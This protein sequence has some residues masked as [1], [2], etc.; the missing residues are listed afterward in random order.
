MNK[1]YEQQ[2]LNTWFAVFTSYD[3]ISVVFGSFLLGR[4][5]H[6]D[7]VALTKVRFQSIGKAADDIYLLSFFCYIYLQFC[8]CISSE[9]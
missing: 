7:I 2:R 4:N 1:H 5:N 9:R 3:T 6:K 8:V